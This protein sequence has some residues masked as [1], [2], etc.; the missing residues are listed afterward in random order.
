MNPE[1][2]K[3]NAMAKNATIDQ[4]VAWHQE[5]TRS[6]GCRPFPKGLLALL[7]RAQDLELD[8]RP[9]EKTKLTMPSRRL[10]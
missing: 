4:R 10:R 7:A 1:W 8:Q 5:H 6:C 2:H 9:P 3:K